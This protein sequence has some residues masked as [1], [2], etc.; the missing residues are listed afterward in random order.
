MA[1]H[2][3]QERNSSRVGRS[4]YSVSVWGQLLTH[5]HQ[6]RLLFA[7]SDLVVLVGTYHQY[8]HIRMHHCGYAMKAKGSQAFH[9]QDILI[10]SRNNLQIFDLRHIG[11]ELVSVRQVPIV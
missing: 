7:R 10:S 11:R 8:F 9:L 4:K 3:T 6:G 5:C 1:L 2:G